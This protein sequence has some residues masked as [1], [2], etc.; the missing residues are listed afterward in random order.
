MDSLQEEELKGRL[1]L[2]SKAVVL[3]NARIAEL[4][5]NWQ[6]EAKFSRAIIDA[7]DQRIAELS[8]QGAAR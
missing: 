8:S 2:L 7:R 5:H 1:E 3:A 6:E 4:E